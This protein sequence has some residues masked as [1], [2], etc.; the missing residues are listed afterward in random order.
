MGE[1]DHV[2]P[3]RDF[4]PEALRG[5]MGHN[6]E[7]AQALASK[8]PQASVEVFDGIGHLIPLEAPQRFNET[9]LRFLNDGR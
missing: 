4:A 1:N 7:L 9:I 8:M 6:V 2:A 3:G 5:K